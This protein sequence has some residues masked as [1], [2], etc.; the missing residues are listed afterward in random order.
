MANKH[1]KVGTKL[2]L[3]FGLVL[4]LL[5]SIAAL[6]VYNMSTIHAKLDRVVNE[7]AVKT[8]LVGVMSNA[9]HI[10]ARVSRSVV[11]LDNDAAIE[12]E[13]TKVVGA[14]DAYDK[15]RERLA[16]LPATAAGIA[17][18]ERIGALQAEARNHN[19]KVFE[20]ARAH[21]DAAATTL[22]MQQA[23]PATQKWQD[24]MEEYA[25]LQRA[26]NQADADAAAAAYARART[27]MLALSALAIAVGAV[28]SVLIARN[29]L[30]QLGGEPD[31]AADIAGRI[32]AGDL[33]V[34]VTTRDGDQHS[35][36]HAM[37]MMR[38]ALSAIVTEVRTG[39]QTI[40]AASTQIAAGNQDLSSRTE[41]QASALE[42]T[43]SSMEELTSAVRQNTDNARQANVL[44]DTAA[45]VARQGGSVVAQVVDTMGAINASSRKIV[46]IIG[47]IDGIAFQT[48]ILALNAAVEAARAGEQGR[49]FAVVATEVRNLAQRS[50]S[51]AREIKAL[52]GNSVEKVETGSKLVEQAGQTMVDVVDSVQRVNDI[53][54]EISSAGAEQGAGIEQINQAVTEMDTVTQQNAALV[55][56]A[57]A[58]AEAL[59]L[60]AANLERIVSVFRVDG[61]PAVQAPASVSAPSRRVARLAVH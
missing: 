20:L 57:A 13:M 60:Q 37:K 32:A 52:I 53:M 7:N 11:L 44:A 61:L 29:L 39:T 18:R 51:A 38:D 55:E 41:Q 1:L 21:Q 42:E 43:A 26:S 12:R 22:L 15:A 56:E 27:L 31:Y 23:G 10:V 50:A 48:N 58:A 36:L 5:L 30:R 35:M 3:G 9:V 16:A 19:N 45:S 17:I 34:A 54:V 49:G 28:A 47:V 24:A 59:Q 33:T 2:G 46:D 4:V 25:A 8:E 6:G 40:A 14:R